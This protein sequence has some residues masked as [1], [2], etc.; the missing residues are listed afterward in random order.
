MV[1]F[2]AAFSPDATG[3]IEGEMNPATVA[4]QPPFSQ[5]QGASIV[6][7][8]APFDLVIDWKIFG[9]LVPALITTMA[10]DWDVSAYAE[11]IGLG[12]EVSLGTVKQPVAAF[13]ADPTTLNGRSYKTKLTVPAAKLPARN[14]GGT[15]S[16][17][18]K[19]S[20]TVIL[21]SNIPGQASFVGFEEGPFVEVV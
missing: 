20:F 11:S 16:G 14:A 2:S 4:V 6:P 8:N 21:P 1:L 10:G 19:L 3:F 12:D 15:Q 13:T 5:V 18:Y 17:I 9:S 7:Q